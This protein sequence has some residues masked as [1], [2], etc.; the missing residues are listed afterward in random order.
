MLNRITLGQHK[1]DNNNRKIQLT[2]IFVYWLQKVA[3]F[4]VNNPITRDGQLM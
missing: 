3:D 4:I 2:V 1:S